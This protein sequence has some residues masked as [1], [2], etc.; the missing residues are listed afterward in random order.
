MAEQQTTAPAPAAAPVQPPQQTAPATAPKPAAI[1]PP[2]AAQPPAPAVASAQAKVEAATGEEAPEQKRGETDAQYE[3]RLAKLTREAKLARD[4]SAQH[5]SAAEKARQ[6]AEL[7]KAELEKAKSKRMTKSEFR[8]LVKSFATDPTKVGDVLEDDD[9]PPA[10]RKLRDEL[11]AQV[12]A[13]KEREAA[14]A[15]AKAQAEYQAARQ[16]ELGIVG[17]HISGEAYPLFDGT[18]KETASDHVLTLWYQ[19]WQEMG[20]LPGKQPDLAEVA[21][22]VHDTLAK[23]LT[24]ALQSERSRNFLLGHVPE[25]KALLGGA[26]VRAGGPTSEAQGA[27][28]ANGRAAAPAPASVESGSKPATEAEKKAARR[29]ALAEARAEWLERKKA[30]KAG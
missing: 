9:L 10:V 29:A 6:E 11:D 22:T 18:A 23:N 13:N 25:L 28:G 24:R 17:E 4:E 14:E 3:L 12:R 5:K 30:A 7:L 26:E 27:G 1:A 20:G 19:R 15:Q 8:E 21:Q 16:R 2:A